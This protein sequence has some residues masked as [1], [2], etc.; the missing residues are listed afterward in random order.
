[1]K[2]KKI[3]ATLEDANGDRVISSKFVE[4]HFVDGDPVRVGTQQAVGRVTGTAAGREPVSEYS[5]TV[6]ACCGTVSCCGT[7]C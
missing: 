1:M 2:S 3:I 4:I 6:S 5:G 7:V